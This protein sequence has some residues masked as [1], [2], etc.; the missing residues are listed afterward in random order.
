MYGDH[1]CHYGVLPIFKVGKSTIYGGRSRDVFNNVEKFKLIIF[2]SPDHLSTLGEGPV[3]ASEAAQLL[4]SS[5]VL[6]V[7]P[8]PVLRINWEDMGVPDQLSRKWWVNLLK[9]IR[10]LEGNVA[11]CCMGGH[12]RTGTALSCLAGLTSLVPRNGDPVAFIRS[13][14]CDN[15]VETMEQNRYISRIT[16]RSVISTPSFSWSSGSITQT[17]GGS[18][19]TNVTDTSHYPPYAVTKGGERAHFKWDASRNMYVPDVDADREREETEDMLERVFGREGNGPYEPNPD[20]QKKKFDDAF[21]KKAP[22]PAPSDTG[23]Q[24]RTRKEVMQRINTVLS[25]GKAQDEEPDPV[26]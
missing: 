1:I 5:E 7:Q 6:D 20:W 15:A 25:R 9:D 13:K 26:G 21:G 24:P 19:S 2:C 18:S 10:K 14:Y 23:T 3:E 17:S 16:E 22:A 8:Y 11:V 12:G 4:L